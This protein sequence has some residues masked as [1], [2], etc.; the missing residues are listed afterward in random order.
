MIDTSASYNLMKQAPELAWL[1]ASLVA[2]CGL[3]VGAWCQLRAWRECLAHTRQSWGL[4]HSAP[5]DTKPPFGG[6]ST[7]THR[8]TRA[9]I[10]MPREQAHRNYG[11]DLRLPRHSV[12]FIVRG[13]MRLLG[14]RAAL[15]TWRPTLQERRV[16][17]CVGACGAKSSTKPSAQP[18]GIGVAMPE[19]ERGIGA[20][21]AVVCVTL[22]TLD[23]VAIPD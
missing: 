2:V 13:V 14:D 4:S 20:D 12:R 3:A 11:W 15:G 1:D 7:A 21:C 8:S 10:Y 19:R 23:G 5:T 22:L 18:Q 16:L 6:L 9:A 17:P